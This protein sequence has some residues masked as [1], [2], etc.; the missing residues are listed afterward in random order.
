MAT[1]TD[2]AEICGVSSRWI[3]QLVA[4]GIL[5]NAPRGK[6]DLEAMYSA[7]LLYSR[8]QTIAKAW[9]PERERADLVA[10]LRKSGQHAD[11]DLLEQNAGR[12]LRG[13]FKKAA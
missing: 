5:P 6:F 1:L 7:F 10:R 2:V 12:E 4:E 3:S 11:A 9:R 8:E 13:R